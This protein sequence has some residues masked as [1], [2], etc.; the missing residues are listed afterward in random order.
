MKMLR[1]TEAE[2]KK[3]VTYK[4]KQHL[5][6]KYKVVDQETISFN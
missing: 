2:L 1:N 6:Y 5:Y 3:G 4:K